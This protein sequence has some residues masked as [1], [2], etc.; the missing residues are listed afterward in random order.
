[1]VI[2]AANHQFNCGSNVR[3]ATEQKAKTFCEFLMLFKR[4]AS[5]LI[6]EDQVDIRN[7][8]SVGAKNLFFRSNFPALP[9]VTLC[10][11]KW[12]AWRINPSEKSLD[13]HVCRGFRDL[14]YKFRAGFQIV[15]TDG[16][17]VGSP[18]NFQHRV[19]MAKLDGKICMHQL[20][21]W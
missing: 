18:G 16:M 4:A 10:C 19:V 5:T 7:K 20:I 21:P 8:F 6:H 12:R 2:A 15:I 11:F 13:F 3:R 1:M 9:Y 14:Q 17:I